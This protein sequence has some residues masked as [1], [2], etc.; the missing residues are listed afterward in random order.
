MDEQLRHQNVGRILIN[1]LKA[2]FCLVDDED[3]A[4]TQLSII[5]GIAKSFLQG[6]FDMLF[7][8][9]KEMQAF[10]DK[11]KALQATLEAVKQSMK[12]MSGG[13]KTSVSANAALIRVWD[14]IA[15]NTA[16]LRTSAEETVGAPDQLKIKVSWQKAQSAADEAIN[17]ITGGATLSNT[18]S[19]ELRAATSSVAQSSVPFPTSRAELELFT[20]AGDVGVDQ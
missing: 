5:L 9:K 19:T 8:N 6:D 17:T 4:L 13:M 18:W 7:K 3:G 2:L 1:A 20:L 10:I 14:I 15:E 16:S 12:S 11:V